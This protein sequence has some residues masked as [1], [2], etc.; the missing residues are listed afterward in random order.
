[1]PADYLD[2]SALAKHYHEEAGSP[3]I[4]RLW[5]DPSRGLFVSRLSALEIVSAFAGKARAGVISSAD[6]QSLSRR[7]SADLA[8]IRRLTGVRLRVSHYQEAEQL[9][10]QHGLRCRLRT[11]DAIQLAVALDLHRHHVI[12]RLISADGDLLAVAALEGLDTYN[13]ENPLP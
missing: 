5:S 6:F 9:I 1:M 3:E 10:R 2:T 7:F 4:D 8:R 11:L 13:P 12:Q